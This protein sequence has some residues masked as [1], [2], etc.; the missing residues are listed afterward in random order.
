MADAYDI[1]Y[2]EPS[3]RA[4]RDWTPAL[5]RAAE[6]S[7]DSG[8]LSLAADLVDSMFADDRIKAVLDSRTDALLA[9][10]LTFAEGAGRRKRA[11]KRALEADEDWWAAFPETDLKLLHGWGIMLGVAIAEIRW[12]RRGGR[13]VPR[14]EVKNPRYLRWD[15]DARAW[16]LRIAKAANDNGSTE[17]VTITPGDG[18]WIVYTPYGSHRPWTFGA[19]RALSRWCLLK[20]YAIQ[21]WGFYSERRGQGTWV[22]SGAKGSKEQRAELTDVLRSLA[23][24]AAIVLPDGVKLE[25]VES[26]AS[27][28]ETFK[29][30]IDT[31][32][33]GTAVTVL[34]Q[35]LTTQN[36]G[37]SRAATTEHGKVAL[38]R[39]KADAETLSTTLREQALT[40][41]ADFNFGERALAPW[42]V[43]DT[44]PTEDRKDRAA[45]LQMLAQSIGSLRTAGA[46]IDVRG[47][48]EQFGLPMLPEGT[49]DKRGQIFAWHATVGAVS[50]NEIRE[51]VGL[52]P[53]EGGDDLIVPQTTTGTAPPAQAA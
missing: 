43:W 32:D 20:R 40:W 45:M 15:W 33:N 8:S 44:T 27:N 25:L 34:G 50:K 49:V 36:D 10:E 46:P 2:L 3:T 7:A 5:L 21:D 13:R 12:E 29:A 22:A 42:P 28:W 18:K 11:A 14:I 17:E 24:N 19:Y 51:G 39:T 53:R 26:T 38:G 1:A 52:E 35:N 41:W 6:I 48:L 9:R 31:A 16:K 37:G 47:V 4:Y 30:Q 23:R